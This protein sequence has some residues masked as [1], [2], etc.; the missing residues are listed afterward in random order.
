LISL[1]LALLSQ[2]LSKCKSNREVILN[3][4][5]LSGEALE[6]LWVTD[7]LESESSLR[8]YV[9]ALLYRLSSYNLKPCDLF[10]LNMHGAHHRRIETPQQIMAS[11]VAMVVHAI[12]ELFQLENQEIELYSAAANTLSQLA[13]PDTYFNMN[14][15]LVSTSQ[16]LSSSSSSQNEGAEEDEDNNNNNDEATLSYDFDGDDVSISLLNNKFSSGVNVLIK[17][18]ISSSCLE[19]ISKL[20]SNHMIKYKTS[21]TAYQPK[22]I[23]FFNIIELDGLMIP[24]L[25]L[26]HNVLL[27]SSA[28]QALFRQHLCDINLVVTA[29]SFLNQRLDSFCESLNNNK[30]NHDEED[31]SSCDGPTSVGKAVLL[32]VRCLA[33]ASFKLKPH[34]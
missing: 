8:K 27:F 15:S 26:V 4:T 5:E 14:Q 16:P 13:L 10:E 33:V 21:L 7:S 34:R 12:K 3:A 19:C 24:C 30:N 25:C 29:V 32:G 11:S 20:V 28:N 2:I 6:S 17:S 23:N 9:L 1:S 22:K 18:L 31:S